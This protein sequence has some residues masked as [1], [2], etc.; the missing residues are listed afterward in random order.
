MQIYGMPIFR[1]V[2]YL[3]AKKLY[4]ESYMKTVRSIVS[5]LLVAEGAVLTA[6]ICLFVGEYDNSKRSLS[7]RLRP[8]MFKETS[9]DLACQIIQTRNKMDSSSR[10]WL[11]G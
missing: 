9:I 2:F 8:E 7:G 3:L 11:A 4:E 6:I 1:I 10:R 5:L